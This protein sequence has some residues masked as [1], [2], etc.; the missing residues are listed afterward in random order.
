MTAIQRSSVV[1]VN[2]L[3][4]DMFKRIELAGVMRDLMKQGSDE[5]VTRHPS[6]VT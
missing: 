5:V 6:Y 1:S 3:N 2:L 4:F